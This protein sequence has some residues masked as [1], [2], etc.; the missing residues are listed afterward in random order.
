MDP[1]TVPTATNQNTILVKKS[2]FIARAGLADNRQRAMEFLG[3]MKQNFPEAGHHCWAYILGVSGAP[4]SAAM[5]DDGEPMGC[6]GKPILNVL[7]HKNVGNIMLVV[8]RYFGGIKLGAGGLVRAYSAAAH[9]VMESLAVEQYVEQH[10]LRMAVDFAQ[11]Q[12]LRHW[13]SGHG[14]EL[15]SAEYSSA[16]TCDV[17]LAQRDLDQLQQ[18]ASQRGWRIID[19]F[20]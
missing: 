11:E 2:K 16:V 14:G 7:Q 17:V 10:R 12:D 20:D 9:S 1:T 4:E 15:I 8:A 3:Q 18:A 13:L 6:A 5:S 19:L